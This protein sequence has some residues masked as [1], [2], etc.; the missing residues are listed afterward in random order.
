MLTAARIRSAAANKIINLVFF[1][2]TGFVHLSVAL[3]LVQPQKGLYIPPAATLVLSSLLLLGSIRDHSPPSLDFPQR[4]F[5]H[6]FTHRERFP[7]IKWR[8]ST[9]EDA[10]RVKSADKH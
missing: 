6:L 4:H 3:P 7:L 2:L 10:K 1:L 9:Q 8:Y 5:G